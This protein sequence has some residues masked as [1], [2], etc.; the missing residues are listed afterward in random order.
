MAWEKV[1]KVVAVSACPVCG[2]DGLDF[3]RGVDIDDPQAIVRCGKCGH[4]CP[5]DKF[6]KPATDKPYRTKVLDGF[7]K[8]PPPG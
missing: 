8:K 4:L 7:G 5:A 2:N 3:E 1:A 6:I